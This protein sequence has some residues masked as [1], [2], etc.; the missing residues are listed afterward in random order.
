VV[1]LAALAVTPAIKVFRWPAL[2]DAR[3]MIGVTALVYT[4]IHIVFYFGM[5]SW[6]WPVILP[7]M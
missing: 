1:L 6:N 7:E 2:V 4:L 5:R 3:R